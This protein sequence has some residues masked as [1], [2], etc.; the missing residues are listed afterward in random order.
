MSVLLV[1][2]CATPDQAT[3]AKPQ[4]TIRGDWSKPVNGLRMAVRRITASEP[5][6]SITLLLLAQ[7]VSDKPVNWDG[8]RP[9]YRVERLTHDGR[10]SAHRPM[11][12]ANLRITVQS[13][14]DVGGLHV[15][16]DRDIQQEIDQLYAPLMPGE[17]R[18]HAINL[19]DHQMQQALMKLQQRQD[20]IHLDKVIWPRLSDPKSNGRWQIQISYRPDGNFPLPPIVENSQQERLQQQQELN[21]KTWQGVQLDFP[22]L[23]IEFENAPPRSRQ[24]Q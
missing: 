1:G 16:F 8:F 6:A 11:T 9:P 4:P 13:F 3:D 5:E 10:L 20:T 24:D 22:P 15:Q 2:C 12:D 17:I 14:D 7:N 19:H 23:E 18:L 21:D